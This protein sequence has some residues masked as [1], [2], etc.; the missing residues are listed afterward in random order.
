MAS[1][2]KIKKGRGKTARVAEAK[3]KVKKVVEKLNP[4]RKVSLGEPRE[5][6]REQ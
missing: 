5:K 2:K 1:K 3:Y 4:I 6:Q